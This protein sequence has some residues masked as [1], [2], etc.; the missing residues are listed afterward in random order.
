MAAGRTVATLGTITALG[1]VA[2]ARGSIPIP[3]GIPI[4]IP[5]DAGPMLFPAGLRG[6]PA[7]GC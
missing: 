1:T 4:G 3:I 5:A 2:V 6:I 7:G